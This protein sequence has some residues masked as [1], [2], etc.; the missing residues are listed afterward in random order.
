MAQRY[1]LPGHHDPD[2]D[3]SAIDLPV[4]VVPELADV[5]LQKRFVPLEVGRRDVV[6]DQVHRCVSRILVFY[7]GYRQRYGKCV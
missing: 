6:E 1:P 7:V 3:L 5:V 4:P 2:D